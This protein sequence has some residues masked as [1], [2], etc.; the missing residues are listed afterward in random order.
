MS[1]VQ[2]QFEIKFRLPDGTDIGPRR[3]P[4]AS[5]V[6]TLKETI[7][8]QWPKDKE[9]GPRTVNDVKLINAGKILENNKT[10]SECKSPICDFSGMT[11]MHVVVRAPTSGK[12]SDKRAAKKAKDFRCGCAIM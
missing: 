9:K 4:P 6:A 10:L 5:T 2:E 7:I 1:A 12:Q 3:F 11:T 8:A